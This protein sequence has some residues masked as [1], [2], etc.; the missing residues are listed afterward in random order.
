MANKVRKIGLNSQDIKKSIQS[1]QKMRQEITS[2]PKDIEDILTEAV[3]Y[4][5]SITPIG[6]GNGDHLRYNTYWEKT[7]KGYRI[8]QEGDNV[9]YIEFGTGVAKYDL[10]HPKSTQFGWAYGIGPHIFDTRDG[11]TGWFFPSFEEGKMKWKFT[12][13]HKA[14]MQMYKTAL[15]LEKRLNTEVKM[16]MKRVMDQW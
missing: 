6:D 5:Q 8:V 11:R 13:G 16:K 7:S 10:V 12:E 2:F 9:T 4:C 14:N 1:L 15:W 3:K